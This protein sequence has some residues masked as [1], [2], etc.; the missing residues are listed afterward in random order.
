ML[1]EDSSTLIILLVLFLLAF[2]LPLNK[3]HFKNLETLFHKIALKKY[4]V[5]LAIGVITF[6]SNLAVAKSFYWPIPAVNDEFG[7]LLLSDTFCQGRL[8]NPVHPMWIHFEAFHITKEPT[9]TAKFP[10]GQG[11][12]LAIGQK[13]TG[14]PIAGVWLSMSLAVMALCWMLQAWLPPRWAFFGALLFILKISIFTY[15]SQSFWGGAVATLGGALVFGALRRIIKKPAINNSL[16]FA[17]GLAILANSRPYE[18]FIISLCAVVCLSIWLI[19]KK[20]FPTSLL[21][22]QIV[23]PILLSMLL[24]VVTMGYYNWVVTGKAWLMPHQLYESAYNNYPLFIWLNPRNKLIEYNNKE[25]EQVHTIWFSKH[26]NSNFDPPYNFLRLSVNKIIFLAKFF[27]DYITGFFLLFLFFLVKNKWT[28]FAF[29]SLLIL[30]LGIL[31]IAF[32][33]LPHY[34]APGVC[35]LYF[36]IIQGMRYVYVWSW[37]TRATGK[38]LVWFVPVYYVCLIFYLISVGVNPSTIFGYY[39]TGIARYEKSHWSFTRESLISEL[40]KL[41]KKS[42]IIVKYRQHNIHE[43]W[44]YNEADIDNAKVVWARSLSPEK[45]C[46]L[47]KYFSDREIWIVEISSTVDS[48]RKAD[49][50][51][52]CP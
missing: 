50:S 23:L 9:R 4:L 11:I 21:L 3:K 7:Y 32:V 18:G 5:I 49:L 10:P 6:L 30:L 14:Y 25:F 51:R 17:L 40:N 33:V 35:L 29:V 2:I 28:R 38:L 20:S 44:I 27:L 13:L 31:Q 39:P 22:K 52:L 45:D 42:L 47:I 34:I 24:L 41:E 8:T 16:F 37:R 48:I 36:L 19:K 15:W 43:E 1:Q 12:A 46:Q 26:F